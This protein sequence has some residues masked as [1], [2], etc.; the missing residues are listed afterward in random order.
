MD[1]EFDVK[2]VRNSI[3][4]NGFLPLDKIV[5]RPIQN[6]FYV[7]VEGNRRIAAIKT[8]LKQ[9]DSGEV[10]ITEEEKNSLETISVLVL[11]SQPE[12]IISDQWYLQGI[13]HLSGIKEWGP[14]QKASLIAQM[15]KKE[16]SLREIADSLGMTPVMVNRFYRTF[17]L[18]KQME[19]YDDYASYAG[20]DLFTHF[21][22]AYRIPKI[23][24]Y[25]GWNENECKFLN[26]EKLLEFYSWIIPSEQL[27][28]QRKLSRGKD[29]DFLA[30]IIDVPEA[31]EKMRDPSCDLPE[32]LIKLGSKEENDWKEKVMQA[33]SALDRLSLELI[34]Q[35]TEDEIALIAKLATE[36]KKRHRQAQLLKQ[37]AV[38]DE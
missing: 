25:L 21:E 15:F 14:Y 1:D 10:T 5:V 37:A 8:L 32:V 12:D 30:Q 20:P 18:I 26:E 22:E 38:E 16:K 29:V 31:L 19:Q 27:D 7:V 6:D 2:S 23:R 3:L 24:D 11:N 36:V 17:Q 35:L 33:L 13:R 34:E 28:G 4:Q 9:V